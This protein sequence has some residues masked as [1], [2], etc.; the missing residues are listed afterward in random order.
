MNETKVLAAILTIAANA[1]E[2]RVRDA[3][4]GKEAWRKV[5]EEYKLILMELMDQKL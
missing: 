4:V 1:K 5:V 3:Q 2:P